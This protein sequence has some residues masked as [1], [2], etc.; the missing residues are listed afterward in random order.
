MIFKDVQNRNISSATEMMAHESNIKDKYPLYSITWDPNWRR[1]YKLRLSTIWNDQWEWYVQWKLSCHMTNKIWLIRC[2]SYPLRLSN[3]ILKSSNKT[4]RW[5]DS[6]FRILRGWIKNPRSHSDISSSIKSYINYDWHY[7]VIL[8]ELQWR[9]SE[10]FMCN[11]FLHFVLSV[12]WSK[13]YPRLK[14]TRL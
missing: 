12:H 10:I 8:D 14:L 11:C 5:S 7:D 2:E 4:L 9:H 3:W 1:S 13:K 6:R